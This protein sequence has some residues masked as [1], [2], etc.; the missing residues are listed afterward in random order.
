MKN[1]TPVHISVVLD[2]S[3]S[4]ASIADDVVGEFNTFLDEQRKQDGGGRVSLVQFALIGERQ[5]QIYEDT[6]FASYFAASN[7]P[8]SLVLRSL[9]SRIPARAS[10]LG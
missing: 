2:R 7:P 8:H 10:I 5:I 1:Q 3:G 6:G 9:G 4:M